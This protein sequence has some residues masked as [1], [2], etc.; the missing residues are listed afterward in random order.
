MKI[1]KIVFIFVFIIIMQFI[2]LNV[3]VSAEN[4]ILY[5]AQ[6]VKEPANTIKIQ[7]ASNTNKSPVTLIDTNAKAVSRNEKIILGPLKITETSKNYEIAITIK[8]Q[9]NNTLNYYLL[10]E[11]K[12]DIAKGKMIKD[13][14]SK[15]FYLQISDDIKITVLKLKADITYTE[16]ADAGSE[17][18]FFSIAKNYDVKREIFDLSLKQYITEVN[19]VVIEQSREPKVNVSILENGIQT[20]YEDKKDEI[21]LNNGDL[22]K[23]AIRIYNEGNIDGYAKWIGGILPEGLEFAVDNEINKKYRWKEENGLLVTDYLSKEQNQNNLIRS[24]DRITMTT[25]AYKTINLVCKVNV[26]SNTDLSLINIVEI[27][28][29][30]DEEGNSIKDKDST[31]GNGEENEDDIDIEKIRIKQYFDLSLKKF[32]SEINGIAIEQSREPRVNVSRLANNTTAS[33][34]HSKD[35]VILNDGDVITYTIRIYNEGNVSGYAELVKAILPRGI[36]FD[37]DNEINKRYKWQEEE[38]ILKTDYLSKEQNQNNVIKG[39]NEKSMTALNY[40]DLKLV[41]KVRIE[42]DTGEMLISKSEI[43]KVSDENGN[44]IQDR[45]S[46]V[47]NDEE[48]EDDIDTESVRVLI[49]DLSLKKFITKI[50]NQEIVDREPEVTMDLSGIIRYD[51]IKHPYEVFN[52]DIV[53]YN[54]R[55]YNEGNLDGYAE[56]IETDI[57]GGLTFLPEHEIN[58][59]YKWQ[60]ENSGIVKTDYL[61]KENGEENIIR[62]FNKYKMSIPDYKEIKI[63]FKVNE[64]N[65]PTDRIIINYSEISKDLNEYNIQDK[66]STPRN[67]YDGEDDIDK[68]YLKV[69]CFDL[70][71]SQ[72]IKKVDIINNGTTKTIE[73]EDLNLE[74]LLKI[75]IS[76]NELDTA[77]IKVVYEIEIMNNGEI[78]GYAK[79]IIDRIPMGL[80]FIEE[81]NLNWKKLDDNIIITN[82]LEDRLLVPE[83]NVTIELVLRWIN[84]ENNLIKQMNIAEI[85][86]YYNEYDAKD[87]DSV[88]GNNVQG[89]DDIS[90]ASIIVLVKPGINVL[91]IIFPISCLLI[92][93]AGI[94]LI[95]KYII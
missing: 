48:N 6:V 92:I 22:V 66:D 40:K 67:T 72:Y 52:N 36:L 9:D 60:Y 1:S 4:N 84:G 86:K 93:G 78:E 61:S 24:F 57:S 50:N 46:T 90:D 88:P 80:K 45:D 38:N 10:D 54:I 44:D 94:I 59:E 68:E 11:N 17:K 70:S 51:F 42:S 83:E 82:E 27:K 15:N 62:A 8:D 2:L 95:K 74:N 12:K 19:D 20:T 85:A 76:K 16:T 91:Y 37:E 49:F 87:F 65:L 73:T 35:A 63:A 25:L 21:E 58:V 23:Y 47:D 69:K 13:L 81:D 28:E 75:E 55:V 29:I 26:L 31:P 3:N 7:N 14:V 5:G 34:E 33:Y 30:T 77:I 39:Y 71:L 18:K 41:C 53:I 79:E 43:I 89:E 32:I 64:D 56:E